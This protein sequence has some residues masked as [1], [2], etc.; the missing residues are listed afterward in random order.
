MSQLAEDTGGR[1]FYNTNDLTSAVESA[2]DTGSNYYTLTYTPA[3]RN[4]S[5]SYHEIRV[6]LTGNLRASGYTLSYRHGYY[7]DGSHKESNKVVAAQNNLAITNPADVYARAAMAHGAPTP[8]EILSQGPRASNWCRP[9]RDARPGQSYGF[10]SSH[11][12]SVPPA[13]PSTWQPWEATFNS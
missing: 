9:G 5:G 1:A 11:Q 3:N 4:R 2:I 10:H 12:A 13:S 8:Q 6:T 7:T